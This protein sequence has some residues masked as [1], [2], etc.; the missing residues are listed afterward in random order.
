MSEAQPLQDFFSVLRGDNFSVLKGTSMQFPVFAIGSVIEDAL[1]KNR[2]V[3]LVLQDMHKAYDSVGWHHLKASL[4]HIKMCERFVSFFGNIH[5]N[6]VNRIMTDFGLSNSYVVHDKLDQS[7]VFLFLLWRIFYDLLLCEIDSRFISRSS[8]I[9]SGGGF[10]SYFVAGAFVNNTIWVGNCQTA[11]Q[12]ILDIASGFFALND[13]SINNK[14]TVAIPINQSVRVASLCISGLSISI[15]KKGKAY[16][17][18]EI[19]LSIDGLSKP[20]LT[21]AHSDVHFFTNVVLRKAI[22]DKQFLYLVLAIFFVSLS[23]CCKWDVMLRKGLKSKAGLPHNFPTEALCYP[24]LYSLKSFEQIQSEGKLAVLISFS[25]FFSVLE[26]LFEHRFLDL[27][28]LGWSPLNPLQFPITLCVSPVNNF[29]AG[30]IR[31]FLCNE[32]SLANNLPNAFHSPNHFPVSSIL[33]GSLF[34]NSVHSL[35]QFGVAFGDRLF[36]K[37]GCV[38]SKFLCDEGAS[39]AIS[40]ESAYSSSLSV[41]DT[42]KFSVVF[43]D[44]SVRNYGHADVASGATA[45]FPA[46]NLSV[47]I[48]VLGL[49]SSTM[50]ELQAIALVLECVPSFCSVKGHSG[51]HGNVRADAAAKDTA[52]SQFSL[53]VGVNKCF[54]VAKNMPVSGNAHH[55]VQDFWR[56]S[57][58]RTYLMKTVHHQMPVVMRKQLYNKHYLGVLCLLCCEVEFSDHVFTCSYDMKIRRNILAATS[59][60]WVSFTG[61][62]SLSSSAVL[63]SLDQCCLDIDLYSVL[64]KGFVLRDWCVEAMEVLKSKKK[65]VSVVVGFVGHLVELYCSK[66]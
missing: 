54:L 22:T 2:E 3:W 13:I 24:S 11:I 36:D 62:Y 49:L 41:L 29:L 39:I 48:R 9:E 45:Y 44:G 66:A 34:F 16:R 47:G 50:A 23:V 37:K 42:K 61:S 1:E 8:R 43:M 33:G 18:L 28:V 25:N 20:S 32:L 5:E 38:V 52:L 56:S 55:F 7:E 51:I 15:A 35:K 4:Q 31:I 30:V 10:S 27:Q 57:C 6:R 64:C 58:L 21:K 65:A 26:C 63:R 46:I 60:D 17:Y 59:A 53:P 19:F 40:V 14:K 12:N